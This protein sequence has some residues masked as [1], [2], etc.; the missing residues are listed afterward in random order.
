[1]TLALGIA[2]TT[3]IFSTVNATLLRPLP[4]PRSNEL[5]TSARAW[6][7]AAS[8]RSGVAGR[9]RAAGR[10]PDSRV[11]WPAYTPGRS[12]RRWCV[13]TGRRSS[14]VMYGVSEG[15]FEVLGLPM[16]A[17]PLVHPRRAR[18]RPDVMRR[19]SSSSPT[20]P[21]RGC[22]AATRRSSARPS[23]SPKCRCVITV[24]GVA[25]PLVDLPHGVDFWF[26]GRI[27]PQRC[28]ARAS[29]SSRV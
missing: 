3:A 7:T 11:E 9:N 15:F 4:Y 17:R 22:S 5:S 2:A 29:M 20:A 16:T 13:T 27:S 14:V 25:S 18:A 19:S 28:R 23:A 6:W 1:M 24:I 8:H 26:N 12:T 21:G 10:D